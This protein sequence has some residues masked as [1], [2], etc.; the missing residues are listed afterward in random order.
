MQ[1]E[2]NLVWNSQFWHCILSNSSIL[3]LLK[4]TSLSYITFLVFPFRLCWMSRGPEFSWLP[5]LYR[6][7]SCT[8]WD[9]RGRR[10]ILKS[11]ILVCV[12]RLTGLF[13]WSLSLFL[14]YFLW[15]YTFTRRLEQPAMAYNAPYTLM[16]LL[17]HLLTLFSA[18]H[19]PRTRLSNE[20]DKCNSSH[21]IM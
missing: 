3:Y 20:P 18:Y 1:L 4:M 6:K 14:L 15:G 7:P 11:Y 9:R 8:I 5:L 16:H 19:V 12:R 2:S 17:I 21:N 10:K 13:H